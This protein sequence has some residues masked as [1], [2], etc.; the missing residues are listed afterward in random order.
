MRRSIMETDI[1]SLLAE[2]RKQFG[3]TQDQTAVMMK[4]MPKTY[5]AYELGHASPKLSNIIHL[6]KAMG[7][8]SLDEF[9]S[10]EGKVFE[11]SPI[12]KKYNDLHR[13]NKR[14]VDFILS[15]NPSSK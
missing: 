13:G 10:L 14:I 7:F 11:L 15:Q 9:L 2:R 3:T 5:Q 12:Q 6:A 1:S 4:C 8:E